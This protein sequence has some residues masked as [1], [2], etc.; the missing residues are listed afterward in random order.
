MLAWKQ[1]K[2]RA[3]ERQVGG[4]E[5]IRLDWPE[6]LK[7]TAIAGQHLLNVKDAALVSMR[8]RRQ[9]AGEI[10][11]LLQ[12]MLLGSHPQQ[13]DAV[14]LMVADVHQQV[15]VLDLEDAGTAHTAPPDAH[16]HT[17]HAEA[18]VGSGGLGGS[19]GSASVRVRTP[20]QLLSSALQH[21]QVSLQVT[22]DIADRS[23]QHLLVTPLTLTAN[24]L[25]SLRR[26]A[27]AYPMYL[28]ALQL[29]E[30]LGEH[31][32]VIPLLVNFGISLLQ[33]QGGEQAQGMGAALWA[34][35]QGGMRGRCL[36]A[37]TQLQR[38]S[39]LIER[40]GAGAGVGAALSSSVVAERAR[41]F[42]QIAEARCGQ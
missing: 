42:L 8:E 7:V 10:L 4:F 9:M 6:L 2:E 25:S 37:R 40:A 3:E 15:G 36:E 26:F 22:R 21:F 35:G 27:E 38:A 23:G 28:Q 32:S 39:T 29:S 33:T 41:E 5:D 31:V 12:E 17:D 34:Q 19:Q 1:L 16:A 18:E 30:R 14:M 20:V 13:H 24:A 11:G